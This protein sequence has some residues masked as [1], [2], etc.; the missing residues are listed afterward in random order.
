MMPVVLFTAP[1]ELTIV[2]LAT[3]ALMMPPVAV[4]E[5]PLPPPLRRRLA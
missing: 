3:V 4:S 5:M 1:D 2:V